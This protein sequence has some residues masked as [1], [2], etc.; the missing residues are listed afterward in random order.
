MEDL[1]NNLHGAYANR[2]YCY[3]MLEKCYIKVHQINYSDLPDNEKKSQF[4]ILDR[5]K[6]N[7]ISLI[8]KLNKIISYI[9]DLIESTN[10]HCITEHFNNL[11]EER[12]NECY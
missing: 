8:E 11:I 6:N 5:K 10:S 1:L 9:D 4:D 3:Y 2:T 7:F 12:S